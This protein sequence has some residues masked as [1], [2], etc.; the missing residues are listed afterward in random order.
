MNQLEGAYLL[1]L[2]DLALGL[3]DATQH[4]GEVPEARLGDDVVACEDL[5]LVE[6]GAGVALGGQLAADDDE[7]LQDFSACFY[8]HGLRWN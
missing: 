1:A 8:R 6:A 4:G 2:D 3:L 5:H 7:L